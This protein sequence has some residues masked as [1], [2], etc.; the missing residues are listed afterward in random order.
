ML[1]AI[2][3]A[4]GLLGLGKHLV[5][6]PYGSLQIT[7]DWIVLPRGHQARGAEAVGITYRSRPTPGFPY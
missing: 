6:A 7:G 2:L 3:G 5:V 1:F 4:G